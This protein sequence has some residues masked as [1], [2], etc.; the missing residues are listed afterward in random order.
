MQLLETPAF[1]KIVKRLHSNQRADL[2][3]ALRAVAE[4]PGLGEQK[5]G[6]LAWLRVYKFRMVNQPVLLGY[7]IA[8]GDTLILHTVGSHENFYRDLKARAGKPM[9]R[10][11]PIHQDETPREGGQWKGRVRIAD[12]FDTPPD[13]IAAAFGVEP[14]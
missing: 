12:E 14:R 4:S 6:D 5:Q 3:D 8:G 10:L 13:D 1:R 7:E 2:H 11:E 9:V